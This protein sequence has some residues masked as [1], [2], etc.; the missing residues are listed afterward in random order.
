MAMYDISKRIKIKEDNESI[1]ILEDSDILLSR[2]VVFDKKARILVEKYFFPNKSINV[3]FS[4]INKICL[5]YRVGGRG[6]K[7]KTLNEFYA[8]SVLV[9]NSHKIDIHYFN[10]Y[11]EANNFAK[12]IEKLTGK[13]VEDTAITGIVSYGKDRIEL[14]RH[15]LSRRDNTG[16]VKNFRKLNLLLAALQKHKGTG[17][18]GFP[19][20]DARQLPIRVPLEREPEKRCH[21]GYRVGH[22]PAP[23]IGPHV[24]EPSGSD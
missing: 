14:C 18:R 10:D 19:L 23:R 1:L 13:S 21:V 20:R 6:S 12:Y 17:V 16:A 3:D 7:M 22:L 2:T 5:E 8:V 4:N 24:A 11:A 15:Q 9:N